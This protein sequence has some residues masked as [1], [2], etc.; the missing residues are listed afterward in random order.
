MIRTQIQL[1]EAVYEELKAVAS[2]SHRSIADCI[3]EGI[4]LF[5]RSRRFESSILEEVAG[6]FSP[7]PP[8]DMKD[9]DRW[10]A[11]AVAD[12]KRLEP[13]H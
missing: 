2:Q 8:A 6:K 1:V 10:F 5:L 3:R 7:A 11:D 12:S 4:G 9:H 13:P